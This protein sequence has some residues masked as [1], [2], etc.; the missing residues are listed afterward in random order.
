MMR[1]L[2]AVL[3][4]ALALGA[5]AAPSAA[6]KS[7]DT[8]YIADGLP[9]VSYSDELS[10]SQTRDYILRGNKGKKLAIDLSSKSGRVFFRVYGPDGSSIYNSRKDGNSMSRKIVE[11]GRYR[12]HVHLRN[13]EDG[14]VRH[15]S[16]RIQEK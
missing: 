6:K 10:G 3:I 11:R 15:Y 12:I 5:G 4:A 16:L 1:L 14:H 13:V 7:D 9:L 2:S 8:V